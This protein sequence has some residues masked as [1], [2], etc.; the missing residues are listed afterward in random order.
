MRV[1]D[2]AAAELIALP[3]EKHVAGFCIP[4]S[5]KGFLNGLRL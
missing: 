1:T 4:Y 2:R 5:D 3:A